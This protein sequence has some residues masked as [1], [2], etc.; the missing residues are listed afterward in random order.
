MSINL[1]QLGSVVDINVVEYIVRRIIHHILIYLRRIE[2]Q[3]DVKE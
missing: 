1:D 2:I 3:I